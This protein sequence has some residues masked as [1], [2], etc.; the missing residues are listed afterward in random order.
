MLA[1]ALLA[2]APLAWAMIVGQYLIAFGHGVN[3][4][5]GQAG[6]VAGS[7]STP[8]GQQRS[9]AL[10]MVAAFVVGGDCAVSKSVH[11]RWC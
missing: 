10:M 4:P 8:A 1:V 9:Q 2:G 7:R 5:C 11:G 6:A 3:Q